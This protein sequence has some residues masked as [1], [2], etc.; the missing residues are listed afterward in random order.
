MIQR[1]VSFALAQPLFT[2]LLAALFVAGGIVAFKELPIEA[3]PDVSDVQ[4]TVIS[5]FPGHAAEEVE[6]QVTIPIETELSGLP[7]S[8]RMFSHTQFGL[9]FIMLTFDDGAT[10]YFARQQVLERLKGAELPPGVDPQLAPLTTPIGEIYRYRIQSDSLDARELRSIQD[11]VVERHLKMVPGVADVVSFGGSIKQ[12]QVGVDLAK[13]KSYNIALQDVF[14]ALGKSNSNAGDSY[15]EQ[16]SQIYLIRGIGLLRSSEDILKVVITQRQGTPLLIRDV[17]NVEVSSVPRQGVMGQDADD[18]VVTG[19]VVMRKGENPSLVLAALKQK[20]ASLNE[21][22]LPKD[23]HLVSYYDRTWLI[24]TTL[25]I[26]GK[27]LIEGAL[28]VQSSEE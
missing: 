8:V 17:A 9:S 13:L 5:L 25:H 22:I 16:G 4:V 7:H 26:V 23:V 18:D 3:F 21:T 20:V 15:I 28:L 14:T 12:Y 19:I 1:I 11:W 2:F 10:D 27:N 24:G 6:K